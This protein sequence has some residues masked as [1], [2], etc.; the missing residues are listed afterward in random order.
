MASSNRVTTYFNLKT[1]SDDE[2]KDEV[3]A[4]TQK[5]KEIKI[6]YELFKKSLNKLLFK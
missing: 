4:K 3:N 1:I 5:D 2:V 6:R